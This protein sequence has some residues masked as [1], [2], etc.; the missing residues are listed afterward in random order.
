VIDGRHL[1]WNEAGRLLE[2]YEGW[3]FELRIKD[4]AE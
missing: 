1:P 2:T 3:E 4:C